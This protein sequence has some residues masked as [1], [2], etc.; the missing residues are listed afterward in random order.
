VSA[1]G[2]VGRERQLGPHD[3]VGNPIEASQ[4]G[5]AHQRGVLVGGGD[6]AEEFTGARSEER[7]VAL[8]SG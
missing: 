4:G 8:G 2:K 6:S 3:N 1:I 7:R 5:V